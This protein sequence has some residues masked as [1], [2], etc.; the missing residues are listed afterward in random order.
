MQLIAPADEAT[1][2]YAL[3]KALCD[4]LEQRGKCICGGTG[5]I[6]KVDRSLPLPRLRIDYLKCPHCPQFPILRTPPPHD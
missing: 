1:L 2:Q 5:V 4:V 3:G 6:P